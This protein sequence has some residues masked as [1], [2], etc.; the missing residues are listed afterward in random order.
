MA[1]PD[2]ISKVA[3]LGPVEEFVLARLMPAPNRMVTCSEV[4]EDYRRW[5]GLH[6]MVPLREGEFVA[7]FE[8]IAHEAG[9]TPRQRGS[10]LSFLDTALRDTDGAA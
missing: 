9:I 3:R 10:N 8:A 6:G 7:T 4:F 2:T 5:C 1:T